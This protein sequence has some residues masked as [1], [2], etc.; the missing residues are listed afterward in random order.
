[1]SI[2]LLTWPEFAKKTLCR[3]VACFGSYIFKKK[4]WNC[5]WRWGTSSDFKRF[6]AWTIERATEGILKEE[7]EGEEDE[8]KRHF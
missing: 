3:K 2:A 8:K 4:Y 6:T 5:S 1:M 7:R